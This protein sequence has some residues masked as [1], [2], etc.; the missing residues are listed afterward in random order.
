ME[1]LTI[2]K[3]TDLQTA[4]GDSY[5]KVDVMK[6]DGT[7]VAGVSA[8]KFKYPNQA[9]LVEGAVVT[10]MIVI[11]GNYRNLVSA[12]QTAPRGNSGFKTAQIE[13]VMDVKRQDISKFQ[14][15]KETS[16]KVASTMR[17]AVDLAIAERSNGHDSLDNTLQE[18]IRKWRE[19]VWLEWDKT[20]STDV[21]PF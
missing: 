16:I 11:D 12:P 20:T 2:K 17:M 14:D 9:E 10:A 4:N 5:K 3:V 21:P 13:K 18:S 19:W 7:L 1:Q 15:N 8:F 6:A